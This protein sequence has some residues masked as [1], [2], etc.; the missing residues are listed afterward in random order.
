MFYL[1]P[2]FH[3]SL[4][5]CLVE[6]RL[7]FLNFFSSTLIITLITP[8]NSKKYIKSCCF[9]TVIATLKFHRYFSLNYHE[10]IEIVQTFCSVYRFHGSK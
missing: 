8:Q 4:C 10:K 2:Y 1:L 7:D 5:L 3:S 6:S 9:I